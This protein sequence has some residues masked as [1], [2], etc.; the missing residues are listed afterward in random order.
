MKKNILFILALM[1]LSSS[2]FAKTKTLPEV[3]QV[4]SL[5]DV[6]PEMSK[7]LLSGMH[8]DIAIECKEGTSLPL[9]FL[10]KYGFFSL[11]WNPQLTL[12][13]DRPCYLRTIK[14]RA[15]LSLDLVNWDKPRNFFKGKAN[16][17]VKIS[18]DKSHILIETDLAQD[19]DS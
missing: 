4:I 3:R 9:Q 1:M 6:T 11:K 7:E 13:V 10:T 19:T 8:P 2:T 5:T 14:R 15:Y 16:T 12:K 18:N 17:D